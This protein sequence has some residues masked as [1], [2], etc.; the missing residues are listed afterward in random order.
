[1]RYAGVDIGKKAGHA[2]ILDQTGNVLA[3]FEFTNDPKGWGKLESHLK[4]GDE[5]IVEALTYA[6]PLIDH[7]RAMKQ[8]VIVA[9]SRKVRQIAESESKT[10]QKDSHTLAHL[11]RVGYLPQAYIPDRATLRLRDL[12]RARIETGLETTRTTNRIHAYLDRNGIRPPLTG[13]KLFA[14]LG[15]A[16]L[17]QPRWRD[18]RD[19]LLAIHVGQL[20][21]L[22]E[23]EQRLQAE[24]AKA[25]TKHE[26]VGPL[27]SVKGIDVY[28]ALV[29]IEESGDIERFASRE[30]FRSYAGCAPRVRESSG[31]RRD[32][33]VVRSCNRLL[34]YVLGLAT[35]RVIQDEHSNPIRGYYEAQ[36][37][38]VRKK[39]RAKARARRKV[40]DLIYR[41]LKTGEPCRWTPTAEHR[42]KEVRME[43]VSRR[44]V[45]LR[46]PI[47]CQAPTDAP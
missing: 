26:R 22:A 39:Q 30:T 27:L 38:R 45:E 8:P 16:W 10:D 36:L 29:L 43:R 19:V 5:V 28:T 9:H 18:E 35:E 12:L 15:L 3:Q 25:G 17:K 2:T 24:L 11:R 33:G 7:F 23:R 14:P 20:E 47:A 46:P 21:A 34:K 31:I 4:P 1:M 42:F 13:K 41:I 6:Y 37:R 40:C 44:V 32:G